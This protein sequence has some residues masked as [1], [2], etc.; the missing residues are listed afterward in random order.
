MFRIK[1]SNSNPQFDPAA[2]NY[3]CGGKWS[4]LNVPTQGNKPGPEGWAM[5]QRI[6]EG[7]QPAIWWTDRNQWI[8]VE[9]LSTGCDGYKYS[10]WFTFH[11]N[12]NPSNPDWWIHVGAI[13][14]VV[15]GTGK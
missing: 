5:L 3:K 11:T 1:S 4:T 10:N 12:T 2:L 7:T 14:L 9:N 15:C 13:S 8:E 6:Y